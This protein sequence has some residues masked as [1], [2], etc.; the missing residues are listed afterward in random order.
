MYEFFWLEC[1]IV[2]IYPFF[3]KEF[4]GSEE[5]DLLLFLVEFS[6]A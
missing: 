4:R 2:S 5:K 6:P 3:V 1:I